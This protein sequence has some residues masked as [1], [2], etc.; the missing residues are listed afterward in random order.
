MKEKENKTNQVRL[1]ANKHQ[2]SNFDDWLKEEGIYEEVCEVAKKRIQQ[3]DE[4][5]SEDDMTGYRYLV[6][7]DVIQE[8]DEILFDLGW[9][10]VKHTIGAK[11][12]NLLY[13]DTKF[14]RRELKNE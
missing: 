8:D 7:G 9:R 3:Y 10:K 13:G 11:M 4:Y 2:G 12:K 5:K 6:E 14:F 1:E